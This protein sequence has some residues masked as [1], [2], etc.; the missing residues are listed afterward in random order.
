MPSSLDTLASYLVNE[1]MNTEKSFCSNDIEF[2]LMRKMGIFPYEYLVSVSRLEETSL[3]PREAFYSNLTE[4]ECSQEDYDHALKVWSHISCS[5]LK[6]Y[7]ELYLKTYVFILIDIFE[8]FRKIC[9]QNYSFDPAQYFTTPGL[10]WEAMLKTTNIQLE[11]LT[12]IDMYRFIQSIIRGCLVQCC[13]RYT[14]ANNK[15]LSDYYSSKEFSFL[16]YVDANNLCGWAMSQPLP[17][18]DFK[19]MSTVDIEN[20]DI[21]N[22]PFDSKYGYF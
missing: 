16:G 7:L 9:M 10:S 1:Q 17:Y 12:D 3:P 21:H 18:K 8:N 6:D 13:H 20:F 2:Q 11:L 4:R 14:K 19:W 5:T 15:Y 22:I